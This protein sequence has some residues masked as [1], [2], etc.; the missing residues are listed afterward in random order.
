MNRTTKVL[1]IALLFFGCTVSL[2]A[3]N[4]QGHMLVADLVWAQVAALRLVRAAITKILKRAQNNFQPAGNSPAQLRD[5]FDYAAVFPDVI[6]RDAH[7]A[8]EPLVQPMNETFW[9]NHVSD[10]KASR[11]KNRCKTWHY[12]DTPIRRWLR[13]QIEIRVTRSPAKNTSSPSTM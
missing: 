8:Y 10:P 4:G 3:W 9:P 11:E 5:A 2:Q 12:Y 13:S 1:F 7:T 6:K